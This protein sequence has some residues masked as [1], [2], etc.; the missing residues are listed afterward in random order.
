MDVNSR[1]DA[2]VTGDADGPVV[3]L[4]PDF[5]VADPA[6]AELVMA[7]LVEAAA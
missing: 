4:S 7:D 5:A 3:M 6:V 2:V 1:G